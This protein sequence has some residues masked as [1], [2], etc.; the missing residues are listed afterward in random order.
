MK[1]IPAALL[2]LLL[3][4]AGCADAPSKTEAYSVVTVQMGG[5]SYDAIRWNRATGEAYLLRGQ[6]WRKIPEADRDA[7]LPKGTYEVQFIALLNDWG[8]IRINTA[9]GDSWTMAD[10][11]W[12]AIRS[13]PATNTQPDLPAFDG[14]VPF[15]PAEREAGGDIAQEDVETIIQ[16]LQTE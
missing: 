6:A 12:I 15:E 4:G 5:H 8:A 16:Q 1:M 14:A 3:I 10:G 9:T 2:F 13:A 7:V 11:Q